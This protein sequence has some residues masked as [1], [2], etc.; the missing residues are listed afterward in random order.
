MPRLLPLQPSQ[1]LPPPHLPPMAPPNQPSL[2][3]GSQSTPWPQ[4]TPPLATPTPPPGTIAPHQKLNPPLN[5]SSTPHSP[6]MVS[7]G[8][9][10]STLLPPS[11][12]AVSPQLVSSPQC[13]AAYA[14]SPPRALLPPIWPTAP[15]SLTPLCQRRTEWLDTLLLYARAH[16]PIACL[17]PV[18]T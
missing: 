10:D 9:R 17:L 8:S 5:L 12:P 3:P 11:F 13:S 14:F 6:G 7:L 15:T 1:C 16:P 18:V 2:Q 4:P